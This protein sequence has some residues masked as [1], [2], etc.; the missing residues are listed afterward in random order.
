MSNSTT[1]GRAPL[2][3]HSV[4]V[5]F[6]HAENGQSETSYVSHLSAPARKAFEG[7]L[8][9]YVTVR[10]EEASEQSFT[11]LSFPEEQEGVIGN[12]L[13]GVTWCSTCKYTSVVEFHLAVGRQTVASIR[14]SP[15]KTLK[16]TASL[17]GTNRLEK[18]VSVSPEAKQ[19]QNS[20][21]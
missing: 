9:A 18:L 16:V 17:L 13:S 5:V 7:T 1:H 12:Y 3:V 20:L 6:L 11:R 2:S 4:C 10:G 8:S 21:Q 19:Q 14:R 15:E